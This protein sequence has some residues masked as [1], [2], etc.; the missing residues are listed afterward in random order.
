MFSFTV[1]SQ[2]S[3]PLFYGLGALDEGKTIEITIPTCIWEE[4]HPSLVEARGETLYGDPLKIGPFIE[5]GP[6]PWG[7]GPV[8]VLD[9]EYTN[10]NFRRILCKI[11]QLWNEVTGESNDPHK[12]GTEIIASIA[13]L[14]QCINNTLETPDDC[15][16]TQLIEVSLCVS[17]GE[18]IARHGICAGLSSFACSWI[19]N[20]VQGE[21]NSHCFDIPE[22]TENMTN[23]YLHIMGKRGLEGMEKHELRGEIR[24]PCCI[25]FHT[26][27]DRTML[28]SMTNHRTKYGLELYD[29]NIDTTMQ[30]LVLLVGLATFHSIV[31]RE[32]G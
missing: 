15:L 1:T 31:R 14:L 22:V 12:R 10:P 28:G 18:N 21:N 7:F 25:H 29:H 6:L 30:M 13:W 8:L 9:D 32:G 27:G 20:R 3:T 17:R 23:A 4:T 16:E 24:S 5:P 26:P 11:P 2:I 19:E